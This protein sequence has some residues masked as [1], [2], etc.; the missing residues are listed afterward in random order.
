MQYWASFFLCRKNVDRCKQKC[1]STAAYR[2]LPQSLQHKD[3]YLACGD[4][5]ISTANTQTNA[6]RNKELVIRFHNG[7]TDTRPPRAS[8]SHL[9]MSARARQTKGQSSSQTNITGTERDPVWSAT[10]IHRLV[11]CPM[12]I[13][14][15]CAKTSCV[16]EWARLLRVSQCRCRRLGC[17]CPVILYGCPL[18]IGPSDGEEIN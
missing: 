9:R 14:M 13:R 18:L 17:C 3:T 1:N 8:T 11:D 10:I 16:Q 5:C 2:Y 12:V 7:R 15:I 6:T 4:V